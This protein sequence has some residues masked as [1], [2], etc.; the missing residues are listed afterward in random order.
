MPKRILI[1]DDEPEPIEVYRELFALKGYATD[2]AGSAQE[3]L[4]KIE[5]FKPDLVTLDI[6]FGHGREAEGVDIVKLIR[7][8]WGLEELPILIVSGYGTSADFL[9]AKE[10]GANAVVL[11]SKV[12][13]VLHKAE[14]LLWEQAAAEQ[15][16]EPLPDRM[17]G[18]GTNENMIKLLEWAEQ[19]C[20]VLILGETGTGKNL[21]AE[22]YRRASRRRNKFY[23]VSLANLAADLMQAELFGAKSGSF[24]GAKE[25][26]GML[27]EGDKGILFFDEI[28]ELTLDQQ[29]R[30]LDFLDTREITRV[31]SNEKIELDVVILAA[32]NQD[33]PRREQEK[34]FRTDLFRRLWHNVITMPPLRAIRDD[35]PLLVDGFLRRF[36]QE[37]CK[38]VLTVD[39]EVMELF[40][41]LPWHGNTGELRFCISH[42]V[43]NCKGSVI[44]L[45]DIESFLRP[46]YLAIL[47]GGKQTERIQPSSAPV[48]RTHAKDGSPAT[49]KD[50]R[51]KQEAEERQMVEK[52]YA[53]CSC[54][55]T[56]AAKLVGVSRERFIQLLKKHGIK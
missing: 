36:N 11:K 20:D 37:Y 27:E 17:R 45:E 40:Q 46:E 12:E 13:A 34:L 38:R 25:R 16:V 50:L 42:G 24:T 6:N 56:R 52:A 39:P 35:I 5:T 30:L 9:D 1:V 31:G 18:R 44:R 28:G 19:E 2:Q 14:E 48:D 51:R 47:H 53:A 54:N 15:P 26:K 49:L 55:Q 7:S 3:T 29:K 41:R 32:T 8:R 4:E 33:L 21:A 10:N 23:K 43:L 22:T